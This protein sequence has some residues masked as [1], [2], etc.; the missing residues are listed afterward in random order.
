MRLASHALLLSADSCCYD[1]EDRSV[2][3]E[4]HVK[5]SLEL[6]LVDFLV[7]ILDVESVSVS[8]FES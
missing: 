5:C 6:I 2:G 4:E 1:I 7:Q 8:I 3:G